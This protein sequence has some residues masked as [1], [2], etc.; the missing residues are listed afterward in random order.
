[1]PDPLKF[2]IDVTADTKGA[3][4]AKAAL[5]DVD[6]ASKEINQSGDAA[7]KQ[8]EQ[9]TEKQTASHKRLKEAI[10]GV[11]LEFPELAHLAHLALNP[12][13]LTLAGI[14]LVL[15][16]VRDTFRQLDEV[17]QTP[18]FARL[19][20]AVEANKEAMRQ[21]AI[22]ALGFERQLKLVANAQQTVTQ[23]TDLA[24]EALRRQSR[25][26]IEVTDAQEALALAMVDAAEKE[27]K[28]GGVEAIQKRL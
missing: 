8:S 1:M 14:V 7:S 9:A 24:I 21:A 18:D 19:T 16:R 20:G 27:G 5:Q 6:Q 25:A 17:L 2:P 22:D 28:I 26:Q 11:A 3:Q 15:G 12:I 23:K 10:K 13:S 4:E